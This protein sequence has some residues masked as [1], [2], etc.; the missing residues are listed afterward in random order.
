MSQTPARKW[1]FTAIK[2][3]IVALLIW[4]IHR[5]LGQAF[6]EL[7]KHPLHLNSAWLVAAGG[8]YLIAILPS[9]LFWHRVMRA[10]G[11]RVGLFAAI[12]AY[13]IGHLG[14][15]V[16]GKAIVVVL[17]AGLVRGPQVSGAVAAV[18]VFVETLT[19][20]ASGSFLAAAT[21][22]MLS[23]SL[24]LH[25]PAV[26]D[27]PL[28]LTAVAFVFMLAS[29]LPT[30]PPVFKRLI[31]LTRVGRANPDAAAQLE[32]ID[33]GT[34]LLGWLLTGSGWFIM[35][36]SLISVLRGMGQASP[37]WIDGLPLTTMVVCLSVVAGF[38]S[39]IPG[40]L[41]VRDVVMAEVL[42]RAGITSEVAVASTILLRLVWLMA[43]L[44]AAGAL[45]PIRAKPQASCTAKSDAPSNSP[46]P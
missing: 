5:T 33:Y 41:V 15:Y 43:E 11:Q 12:R 2:L 7:R 25:L 39:F 31:R 17:R 21:L 34:L 27:K 38:M 1:L 22:A 45:Y 26:S 13:F 42:I 29:G 32:R 4:G 19:M 20:M 8:L 18:S 35:G 9:A 30:L 3:L 46:A 28:P 40:G 10:M 37:G 6:D 36:L 16:P 23:Q 24:D 44:A 14:K